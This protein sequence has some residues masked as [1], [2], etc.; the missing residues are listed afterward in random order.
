MRVRLTACFVVAA[1]AFLSTRSGLAHAADDNLFHA[2]GDKPGIAVLMNDFTVRLKADARIGSFF[3]D[4]KPAGLAEQ[5]T[6][7]VCRLSGGPCVYEGA[8]MNKAHQDLEIARA[9]FNA[10]VEVLQQAMDA[11]GIPFA[12]QNRPLAL[13]APMYRDIVTR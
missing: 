9:D 5:L 12:T 6:E 1:A 10:L 13:L 7:Q 11:R 2:L 8:P 4:T 3:K